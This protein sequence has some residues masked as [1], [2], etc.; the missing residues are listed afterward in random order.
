MFFILFFWVR[1]VTSLFS[2]VQLQTPTMQRLMST[3]R[4][5]IHLHLR[6]CLNSKAHSSSSKAHSNRSNMELGVV[7]AAT[8]AGLPTTTKTPTPLPP[9]PLLPLR[10]SGRRGKGLPQVATPPV[11]QWSI[12][13][14]PCLLGPRRRRD[15]IAILRVVL[16]MSHVREGC[17]R[18]RCVREG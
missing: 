14:P 11:I 8:L 3:Q 6:L 9:V 12:H 2:C 5:M 17:V 4:G 18:E 16:K 7:V 13:C 10:M 1:F 15:K